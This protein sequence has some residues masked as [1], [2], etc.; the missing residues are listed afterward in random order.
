MTSVIHVALTAGLLLGG[1]AAAS[2]GPVP[3]EELE[4][5]VTETGQ[6]SLS[7]DGAGSNDPAGVTIQV[8]KPND[9]AT[10][11][12][13]FFACASTFDFVINDGDV[14]LDG[15]PITWDLSVVNGPFS[16]VFANVTAIVKPV[17]DAA[18]AGLVDF[19]QTEFVTK[20]ETT[21]TIDG[22]GL[23]VIFDDPEQTTENTAFIL[24]GGQA[25]TGDD[26]A[27]TLAEPLEEGD[28]A[29]MGLGISFGAQDQSGKGGSHFCGCDSPMFSIIDVNGERLTS[30]AG[31]LDDGVGP[32]ADGI[33]ITVGGVGDSPDNPDDPFQEAADG[34]QP[35]IIDDE[36]YDLVPFLEPQETLIFVETLNPSCLI[37]VLIP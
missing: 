18:P 19:L 12:A 7:A 32:V 34:Q 35:R 13:A 8:E 22:C 17:V 16:N 20:N 15:N 24:F 21:E 23:Y 36:L 27:V 14:S 1:A 25:T 10:V 33:L 3:A 31:N 11:R 6:I 9:A 37:F 28:I 30:C 2:A 4:V 5:Q 26:Y 29:Q